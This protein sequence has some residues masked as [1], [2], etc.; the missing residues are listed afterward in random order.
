[1]NKFFELQMLAQQIQ[2]SVMKQVVD[3]MTSNLRYCPSFLVSQEPVDEAKLKVVICFTMDSCTEP[4]KNAM[5]VN[6][7]DKRILNNFAEALSD[8]TSIAAASP[9]IAFLDSSHSGNLFSG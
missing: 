7:E 6:T 9:T 5:I 8:N 4:P 1:M 3:I 2:T